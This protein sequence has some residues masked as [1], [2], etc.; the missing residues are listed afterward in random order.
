MKSKVD[1]DEYTENYNALLRES[2]DFFSPTEEYFARYKI[3]LV[4]KR[5][6]APVHRILEFGCGIGRNIPF[7]Q[8]AF[9][10]AVV[11]GS[12][13]SAASLEIAHR[14]NPTNTF[15][16]EHP[17]H[18]SDAGYDLIFVAGVFHHIPPEQRELAATTLYER[19][20]PGAKLIVFEHNPYNPVTRRI[21]NNCPYDE[22]AVLL[23]PSGLKSLLRSARL[24]LEGQGY[25]LFVPPSLTALLWMENVLGWVPL[26]GQYWVQAS[27]AP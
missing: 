1:F 25:C 21:V 13:I 20:N 22:D 8:Q 26:G 16:V 19:L 23:K 7:L 17:G 4:R 5:I 24:D 6:S 3:D 11:E 9:P 18:A 10:D 12:D 2:T 14:D 15:F 27:R